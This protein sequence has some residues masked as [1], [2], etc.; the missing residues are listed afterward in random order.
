M[1]EQLLQQQLES[2]SGTGRDDP[3]VSTTI[4]HSR[5]PLERPAIDRPILTG[6]YAP[7]SNSG[8]AQAIAAE[9]SQAKASSPNE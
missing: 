4:R 6:H 5:T 3:E 8:Q 7:V 2:P 9:A 1:T